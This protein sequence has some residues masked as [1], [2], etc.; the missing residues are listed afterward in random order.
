MAETNH[1]DGTSAEAGAARSGDF[2]RDPAFDAER[3]VQIIGSDE[4]AERI[5]QAMHAFIDRG[6][7]AAFSHAVADYVRSATARGE[8]I[9]RVL[10]VLIELAE[11]REGRSYPHDWQPSGLRRLVLRGVLLA[12]YGEDAVKAGASD[13][14]RRRGEA[15]RRSDAESTGDASKLTE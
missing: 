5:S 14:R 9:E 11:E 3:L 15:R 7:D 13:Q 6:D 10:A 2:S 1:D 4:S 12:F 8:P